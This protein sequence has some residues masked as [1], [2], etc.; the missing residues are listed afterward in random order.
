MRSPRWPKVLLVIGLALVLLAGSGFGAAKILQ[1]RYESSVTRQ[2]LLAP[3]ARAN[4][5]DASS[6]AWRTGPLNF[7]LLGSDLRAGSP[8]EGQRSDTIIIMQV[9]AERDGAYLI[10]IPRDLLV[11]IPPYARTGY[12]GGRDKVNAAF[13]FGG[14][15][16]G[17]VQLLSATLAELIGI[18]FDGAAVLDFNGFAK[19]VDLLGGVRMCVDTPV[20]SIHTGRFFPLGCQV[21][22]GAEALDYSR[23]RYGLEN[24]D[25]DRQRHDQ[26]LIKA[27]FSTALNGGI[28]HNPLKA[29]QFIRALGNSLTMDTGGAS[30]TDVML[31]LRGLR[32]DALVGV[33]VPSYPQMIGDVSYVLTDQDAAALWQAIQ[34]GTMAQWALEYPRWVHSL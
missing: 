13:Q 19:V 9:N 33:A 30:L 34:Q 20:T 1:H 5:P 27:V 12:Y 26:Q 29:D 15:G 31:A 2:D 3:S 23:Q 8:D 32:P 11:D 4:D 7:L 28:T 24:G 17:G 16:S 10:S 6:T 14:G 22:D 25:Y 21:F 18:K